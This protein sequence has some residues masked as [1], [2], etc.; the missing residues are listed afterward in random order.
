METGGARR[1]SQLVNERRAIGSKVRYDYNSRA[2]KTC[3]FE[4]PPSVDPQRE[5]RAESS[6]G[7]HAATNPSSPASTREFLVSRRSLSH[8]P[9][10]PPP[11][12]P[13]KEIQ[14]A[15][16]PHPL[17]HKP[18]PPAPPPPRDT[19]RGAARRRWLPNP[20]VFRFKRIH[21][22]VLEVRSLLSST[23]P[24]PWTIP[25]VRRKTQTRPAVPWAMA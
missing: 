12:V 13:E 7:A 21:V 16:P 1:S 25:S 9:S 17:T 4:R 22:R 19:R 2:A 5:E 23:P 14:I 18:S 3:V 8:S 15:P 10:S 11:R 24:S 20:M 6:C